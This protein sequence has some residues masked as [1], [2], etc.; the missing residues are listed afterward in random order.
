M[1][2]TKYLFSYNGYVYKAGNSYISLPDP[3][4]YVNK[5]FIPFEPGG[6]FMDVSVWTSFLNSWQPFEDAAPWLSFSNIVNPAGEGNGWGSF[7]VTASA[8]NTADRTGEFYVVAKYSSNDWTIDVSQNKESLVDSISISPSFQD[9]EGSTEEGVQKGFT[10]TSSGSWTASVTSDPGLIITAFTN[11]GSGSQ[12]V[13]VTV[14]NAIPKSAQYATIT[15]IRGS[16]SCQLDICISGI[17]AGT[18]LVP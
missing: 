18:C 1:A 14:D 9:W 15:Y 17:I 4:L 10:L 11:S 2:M 7:R 6:S 16:A 13:Y 5:S 3:S 12:T 8:N